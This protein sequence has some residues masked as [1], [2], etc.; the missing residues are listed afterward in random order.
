MGEVKTPESIK[1]HSDDYKK[2]AWTDYDLMEL[3]MWVHLLV[4]RSSHRSNLEKRG[5]DL[6]DARNYLDMMEAQ[7]GNL[8]VEWTKAKEAAEAVE[9]QNG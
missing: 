7:V 6:R 3:G 1:P 9:K 8:W 2:G 5:K 4:K